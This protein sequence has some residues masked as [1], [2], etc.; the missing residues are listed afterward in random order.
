MH[1][2]RAREMGN[3]ELQ[4][5]LEKYNGEVYYIRGLDCWDSKTYH[6]KAVEHR[7]PTTCDVFERE[8]Q[9]D[10]VS[11]TLITNNYWLRIAKS[12]IKGITIRKSYSHLVW[13]GTPEK[14]EVIV[15][16]AMPYTTQFRGK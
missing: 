2:D 13:Q 6:A 15:G 1:Y 4:A 11:Q 10:D 7:I 16:Y 5:I 3:P 8:V 12:K 9:M 14:K